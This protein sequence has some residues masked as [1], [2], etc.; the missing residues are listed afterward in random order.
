LEI[1][2]VTVIRSASIAPGKTAD[3]LA[4]AH[5]IATLINNKF[6]KKLDLMMPVGGNPARIAWRGDYANLSEWETLSAK[7]LADPEYLALVATTA[8]FVI[9]GSVNDDIWRTI[10]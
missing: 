1:T 5:N 8:A 3:A 2:L 4:F 6:D 9:P 7:L 10:S